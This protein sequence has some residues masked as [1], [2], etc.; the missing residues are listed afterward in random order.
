[1]APADQMMYKIIIMVG[2]GSTVRENNQ[3]STNYFVSRVE[4]VLVANKNGAEYNLDITYPIIS[5]QRFSYSHH[6]F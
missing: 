1:M 2:K 6:Y 3:L 5:D 4:G